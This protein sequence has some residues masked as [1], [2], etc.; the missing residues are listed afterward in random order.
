MSTFNNALYILNALNYVNI[1]YNN[2]DEY[3]KKIKIYCGS[4][5]PT[6]YRWCDGNSGTPDL[7]GFFIYAVDQ[8]STTLGSIGSVNP[9]MPNHTHNLS[10]NGMNLSGQQIN[11]H[12]INSGNAVNN[13]ELSN[14][15]GQNGTQGEGNSGSS[16][17]NKNHSHNVDANHTINSTSS[18]VNNETTNISAT[19]NYNFNIGSIN[20]N[21]STIH[22][23]NT[24]NQTS[25]TNGLLDENSEVVTESQSAFYNKYILVG[26]IMRIYQ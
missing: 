23:L 11:T 22:N 2:D 1:T 18:T 9:S 21:N 8:A 16:W 25:I 4:S 26:F 10:M 12:N 19:G 13:Y 7:R 6:G 17:V 24:T 14:L 5:L 15:G 3:T 20:T